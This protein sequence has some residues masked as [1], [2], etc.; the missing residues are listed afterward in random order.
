MAK[1]RF[2][3]YVQNGLEITNRRDQNGA[4]SVLKYVRISLEIVEECSQNGLDRTRPK[5]Y[6]N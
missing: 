2:S 3:N 5:L 1:K 4:E 6:E